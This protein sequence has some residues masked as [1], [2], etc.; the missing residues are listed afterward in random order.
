[1]RNA[2]GLTQQELAMAIGV[3]RSAVSRW[4]GGTRSGHIGRRAIW[5]IYH[6]YLKDDPETGWI[7]AALCLPPARSS[8][9]SSTNV[10]ELL[11]TREKPRKIRRDHLIDSQKPHSKRSKSA[12]RK[13]AGASRKPKRRDTPPQPAEQPTPGMD[14]QAQAGDEPTTPQPGTI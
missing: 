5:A 13:P 12:K 2:A 14:S 3:R 1:M 10:V 6:L 4:E 8:T 7:R 11:K 9:E